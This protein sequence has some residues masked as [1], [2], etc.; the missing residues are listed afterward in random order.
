GRVKGYLL[1]LAAVMLLAL[2]VAGA[3]SLR[4]VRGVTA[5][6]LAVSRVARQVVQQ[7]DFTHRAEKTTDDEIGLLVDSFNAMLAEVGRTTEALERTNRRLREE[8]DER[9]NAEQALRA[10]DR[11]KDEFLATLAHE[12]RNPLA[13]MVNALGMIDAGSLDERGRRAREIIERQL[14]H[15][16]RL[17][18]DLLDVSRIT[19]GKLAVHKTRVELSGV[20]QT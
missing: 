17:V 19:R 13:P 15:M 18:D 5:P 6:V 16:V 2:V 9:S 8:T 20:V 7:R 12:L 1:I 14:A 11:R 3:I 4:L 10:A